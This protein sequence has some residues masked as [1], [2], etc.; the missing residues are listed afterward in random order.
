[1]TSAYGNH[2]R[3]GEFVAPGLTDPERTLQWGHPSKK[4]VA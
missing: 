4:G 2:G 1:M 3:T